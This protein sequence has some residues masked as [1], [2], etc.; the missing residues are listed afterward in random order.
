MKIV[1]QNLSKAFLFKT[2]LDRVS[3]E[4]AS[5]QIIVV[6]G[7]NGSG[8]TTLLRCLAGISM[9]NSGNILFD[10]ETFRRDRTDLRRRLYFLPDF[11]FFFWEHSTIHNI[12]MIVHL[13]EADQGSKTES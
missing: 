8:K 6:L 12:S 4:I 11:P 10:G 5:G 1:L 9:P 3:L 13:Y 2:V 7:A